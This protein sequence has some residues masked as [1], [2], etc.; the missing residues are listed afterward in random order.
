MRFFS[1]TQFWTEITVPVKINEKFQNIWT[2]QI[3]L[4][5]LKAQLIH[6]S[7]NNV[8]LNKPQTACPIRWV[9]PYI[10]VQDDQIFNLARKKTIRSS[11]WCGINI[12]WCQCD[13]YMLKVVTL[14]HCGCILKCMASSRNILASNFTYTTW[15]CKCEITCIKCTIF[16]NLSSP[17]YI[18]Q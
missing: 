8:T 4:G 15:V 1:R 12:V 18:W 3:Y 14:R 16:I 11:I 2:S 5:K 9:F 7:L 10:L 13:F 6:T 17:I